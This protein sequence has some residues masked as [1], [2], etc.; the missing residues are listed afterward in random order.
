MPF[1]AERFERA[2]FEPRRKRVG[3]ESLADFF[4]EGEPP[5]WEVR[6]LSANELHRAMEASRRQG[7]IESIVKAMASSADQVQAVR[8]ALGL[9][10]DTPGEI[11]KRLEMLVLGSVSPTIELPAAVKLAENFPVEF[12]SLTNEITELTGK[13]AE[14]GKPAAV[15]Q[16][17]PA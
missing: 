13:G 6:G 8:K 16:P 14:M 5:E 17:T 1:D 10:G 3:V 7:S 2:K 11:A 15:S 12:L 9:T 4:P